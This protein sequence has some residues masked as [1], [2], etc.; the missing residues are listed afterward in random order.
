[1]K[2]LPMLLHLIHTEP[3]LSDAKVATRS[4]YSAQTVQRYRRRIAKSGFSLEKLRHCDAHALELILLRRQ[5]PRRY[6][7]P[8]N[9]TEILRPS[10]APGTSLKMLWERYRDENTDAMCYAQFTRRLNHFKEERHGREARRAGVKP[11]SLKSDGDY[12]NC[13]EREST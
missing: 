9:F 5:P 13:S 10:H 4:G 11:A 3:D 2:R 7:A 1:M 12:A 8:P 6:R